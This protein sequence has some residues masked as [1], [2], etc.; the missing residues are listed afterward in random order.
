MNEYKLAPAILADINQ[1]LAKNSDKLTIMAAMAILAA[2]FN[3]V[4]ANSH[5]GNLRVNN[6]HERN[7]KGDIRKIP[8]FRPSFNRVLVLYEWWPN[9]E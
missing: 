3:A 8:E 1:Y 7:N 9:T 5:T 4:V 6:Y 2:A